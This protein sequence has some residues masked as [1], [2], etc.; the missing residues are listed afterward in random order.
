MSRRDRKRR[1]DRK[2]LN[3]EVIT[4]SAPRDL[5]KSLPTI[6][7]EVRV[8]HD[9][10]SQPLDRPLPQPRRIDNGHYVDSLRRIH[11]LHDL[12]RNM[13]DPTGV[14][15]D[16]RREQIGRDETVYLPSDHPMCRQRRQRREVLFAKRKAGKGG[17]QKPPQL[18]KLLLKC[19]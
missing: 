5:L 15:Y 6:N 10:Q 17:G 13:I 3:S 1:L 16:Y 7:P 8:R 12:R 2:I 11:I 4:E 9:F 18:P 14:K 19:K